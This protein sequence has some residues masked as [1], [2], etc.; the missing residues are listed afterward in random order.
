MGSLGRMGTCCAGLLSMLCFGIVLATIMGQSWTVLLGLRVSGFDPAIDNEVD[1][2]AAYLGFKPD[3]APPHQTN[4]RHIE[5]IDDL[6]LVPCN[7][8]AEDMSD[9]EKAGPW[10]RG[11]QRDMS[12][13]WQEYHV[14]RNKGV[15]KQKYCIAQCGLDKCCEPRGWRTGTSWMRTI[16]DDLAP[17][18][19]DNGFS[20]ITLVTQGSFDRLDIFSMIADAWPGPK[21]ALFAIY[22]HTDAHHQSAERQLFDISEAAEDWH[23]V[24]VLAY[25]VEWNRDYYS[26]RMTVCV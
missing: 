8:P 11:R 19:K 20:D 3:Q 13:A 12:A 15:H 25:V 14:Q 2:E 17:P 26:K 24:K 7:A 18:R 21:V 10:A 22:N 23:N 4:K 16:K 5:P 9:H 6:S 1:A